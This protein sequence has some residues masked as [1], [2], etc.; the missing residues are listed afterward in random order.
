MIFLLALAAIAIY[1]RWDYVVT[2]RR[3]EDYLIRTRKE[4]DEYFDQFNRMH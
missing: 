4:L 1:L 2:E 3:A